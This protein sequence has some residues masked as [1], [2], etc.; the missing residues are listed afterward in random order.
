MTV[1]RWN[2]NR[3][4][5]TPYLDVIYRVAFETVACY[6]VTVVV[7]RSTVT[8]D[9]IVTRVVLRIA[10]R[11]V[12]VDAEFCLGRDSN[13]VK[14]LTLIAVYYSFTCIVFIISLIC[15]QVK[16]A[17]CDIYSRRSQVVACR[18]TM[19]D[20]LW[21]QIAPSACSYVYHD[22]PKRYTSLFI[23]TQ[24]MGDGG[25][26]LCF[27]HFLMSRCPAVTLAFVSHDY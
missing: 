3:N 24:A 20:L 15:I 4:L 17:F 7:S 21:D 8:A 12:Y 26:L 18:T 25:W 13:T 9:L 22:W 2:T 23:Q 14:H 11:V 19:C 6:T 1:L 5:H 16:A 10:E 27:Q